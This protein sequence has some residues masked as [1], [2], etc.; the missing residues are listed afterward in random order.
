MN[1]NAR[2]VSYKVL[3]TFEVTK[4][5]LDLLE[6]KFKLNEILS[7]Q[8]KKLSKNLING[9]VRHLL[10]LDWIAAR[11]YH[12]KYKKLLI[13]TKTIL[14][15]AFY[16]LI[17]VDHIPSHAT[18]NEYV[19]L[20]KKKVGV[21]QAKMIN[22]MLRNFLRGKVEVDPKK[23]IRNDEERLS[24]Q[25][26]FPRWLIKRWISLWGT[27]ESEALCGSLNRLPD[28]D[29][30]I[31]ISLISVEKFLQLLSDSEVEYKES[32]L[33]KNRVKITNIQTVIQNGWFDI[34]Y[35]SLQDESAAIP[36]ELLNVQ[37]SEVVLDVCSAPG[38]KLTQILEQKNKHINIIAVDV[39]KKRL[40][41]VRDNVKRL[42]KKDVL[43]VVANG[44][45]LPFKPFFNKILLDTPCSGLGVIRKH[46]DIKWRR[47][48][49][50][51]I[52][53]SELQKDILKEASGMLKKTGQ[54]VYSTCTLDPLE[55]GDVIDTFLQD[56]PNKF[57]LIKPFNKFINYCK[58]DRIQTLPQR[59]D[60]DGSFCAIIE[61]REI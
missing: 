26:S 28:F 5:R 55:N 4:N 24:I 42:K 44:K 3:H 16:E 20:G 54:L 61:K 17:F 34:G 14:R 53:F 9:S 50:E 41:R 27:K 21:A 23:V 15:L 43:F 58:D 22:A 18:I 33:F 30:R 47:T 25:Y 46:P 49:D 12:G 6:S 38:G 11:L 40:K 45:Y 51:I 36:V 35:C 8:D 56:N 60:M 19:A 10:Y 48:M 2:E 39:N 13:K 59:D 7:Q 57:R 32:E 37:D 31:N 1:S 29:L 52:E